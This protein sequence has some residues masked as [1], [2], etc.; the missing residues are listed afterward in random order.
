MQLDVFRNKRNGATLYVFFSSLNVMFTLLLALSG[1]EQLLNEK[2]N[3]VSKSSAL[4]CNT[5][6]K[7]GTY[8]FSHRSS[9]TRVYHVKRLNR[10][11]TRPVKKTLEFV[12]ESV[13]TPSSNNQIAR[14]PEVPRENTCARYVSRD[15]LYG[16]EKSVAVRYSSLCNSKIIFNGTFPIDEPFGLRRN[17]SDRLQVFLRFFLNEFF[18]LYLC[19][20]LRK[21]CKVCCNLT[22]FNAMKLQMYRI[23]FGYYVFYPL[24]QGADF[25]NAKQL[26]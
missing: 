21:L 8:N 23:M 24:N 12:P 19:S 15:V 20:L 3:N 11:A 17:I 13:P 5:L 4:S 9:N 2:S 16:F 6:K 14:L 26:I 22:S 25:V 10:W 7:Y 18:I 1:Y